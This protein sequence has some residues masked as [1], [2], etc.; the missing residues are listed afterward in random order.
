MPGAIE[1]RLAE[2]GVTLPDAPAPAATRVPAA[3]PRTPA[4]DTYVVR[5]GDTRLA[6]RV[7]KILP[8]VQNGVVTFEILKRVIGTAPVEADGSAIFEAPA[9]IPIQFQALDE[10]KSW[11]ILFDAYLQLTEPPVEIG[12]GRVEVGE[13]VARHQRQP[14]ETLEESVVAQ[15]GLMHPETDGM[16]DGGGR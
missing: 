6:G 2:L 12:V 5:S 10:N 14:D 11:R 1:S 8:T 4:A 9:G 7:H 13:V 16:A 15:D 3:G